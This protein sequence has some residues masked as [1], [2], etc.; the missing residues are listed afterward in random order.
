[1]RLKWLLTAS[2]YA[3]LAAGSLTAS[4][5]AGQGTVGGQVLDVKDK[6]VANA[7]VTLQATE[8]DQL[9]AT[10]TNVHGRFW[11]PFLPEG[12]YSVRASDPGRVSEW[13][14]VSGSRRGVRLASHCTFGPRKDRA[15]DSL[16]SHDA[17]ELSAE[18]GPGLAIRGGPH[19][20]RRD[21]AGPTSP[22]TAGTH[23]GRARRHLPGDCHGLLDAG[24]RPRSEFALAPR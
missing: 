1:M 14:R 10:E 13:R 24:H 3:M 2:L 9:Q 6:P 4:S 8:G 23:P 21:C 15:S 17:L 11:F 19:R 12:Q 7:H 5:P 18:G 20:S 22:F 16:H